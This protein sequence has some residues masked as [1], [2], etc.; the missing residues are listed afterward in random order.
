MVNKEYLDLLIKRDYVLDEAN[1]ILITYQ[2]L[3]GDL[4][5]EIFEKDI[6]I[7]KYRKMIAFCAKKK[8]YGEVIK[9]DELNNYIEKMM[10]NY[11][12]ELENM[13]IKKGLIDKATE[14]DLATV[15]MCKDLYYKIAKKCHPDMMDEDD[16][17]KEKI[18]KKA[19]A[20][21]KS[22]DLDTLK[23]LYD[24]VRLLED[25]DNEIYDLD[26]KIEKITEEINLITSSNPY[27]LKYEFTP[28]S[29]IEIKKDE[30][31]KEIKNRDDIIVD[32]KKKLEEFKI[33]G[34][35]N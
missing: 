2:K 27:I 7:I 16:I 5:I 26:E 17:E 1:G 4:L 18:F 6:E 33:E 28:D 9:E 21:Y 30:L 11:N 15:K 22:H 23:S 25:L 14:T 3:Y 8:N 34:E 29:I 20:A 12:L 35:Y 32:L 31:K 13:K 19:I 10:N 24:M